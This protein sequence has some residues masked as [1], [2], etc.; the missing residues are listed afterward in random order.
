[1]PAVSVVMPV[2]DAARFL[3]RAVASLQAQT[4]A[5]WELLAVDDASRDA[6]A[7]LLDTLAA[8]DARVRVTR[9]PTNR[10]PA[11]ARNTALAAARGELVAY[12]DADDEFYPDHLARAAAL[13]ARAAVL[14]FRYNLVDERPGP[15][16][17]GLTTH[18]PAARL[19]AVETETIGVPLGVVHRRDLLARAGGF[20]EA[21]GRHRGRDEDGDLWR[22]FARA[23]AT[24]LS[25]RDKSGLYHIRP[26]SLARTRPPAPAGPNPPLLFASYHAYLD[27]SSGA[28][29]STRDLLEDLA[30]H[31]WACRVVCGPQLDFGDG[32]PVEAVLRDHR[33]PHHHERCAPP[34]GARYDL[35]HYVLNGVPVTQY[36]PDGYAPGRPPTQT[37][38]VP[39]L[40]VLGRACDRFRPGVVLTYGGRPI[41]PHLI[42]RARR[43]GAKVVFALHNFAY[44]GAD[45]LHEVDAL[46]VPSGYARDTYRAAGVEAEAVPWPWDR[47]RARADRADG[48]YVTFV[49]PQPTKGVAWF[50]RIARELARRRPDIRFLVVEGR[51]GVDW[52]GRLPAEVAPAGNIDRLPPTPRPADFYALSRLVLVPSL[53]EETFGR[54]AA[55]ALA[56]GLPV[57]ASRRGAL[58]ETLGEAGLLFDIPD[59]Y[60]G[61]TLDVPSAAEV[62]EWADAIGR[63][64]DARGTT[65]HTA[66]GPWSG[67]RRGSR[68]RSGRGSRRSSA[69]SAANNRDTQGANRDGGRG[70]TASPCPAILARNSNQHDRRGVPARSTFILPPP[71]PHAICPA[72][73]GRARRWRR[74]ARAAG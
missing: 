61:Q 44:R 9:H 58:P 71:R 35:F 18:D 34:A 37:E 28:A 36:R 2:Y 23:G 49:N 6:S 31:G 15:G 22:R 42:R 3:R 38:G 57:L 60:T 68:T 65:R 54:V 48:R 20:D 33:L 53:W 50:A 72:Q 73:P 5:D 40:D 21:L 63:L 8:A 64:Y 29:L 26:D 24:F 32:R 55:E 30:A 17:G 41:G 25:V 51:G 74:R 56:N 14:L 39:F 69:G 43:H 66:A 10:G 47:L 7:A 4:F 70:R 19:H 52:L 45:F 46:R 16:R 13:R 62:G 59:R 1:M 11:A 67:R 27:H 12:L